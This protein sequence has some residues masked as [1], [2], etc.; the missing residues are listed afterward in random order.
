MFY[1][2]GTTELRLG[3]RMLFKRFLRRPIP[4]IVCYIPGLCKPHPEMSIEG[5]QYWA[6]RL[7]D[8]TVVSFPFL[9]GQK[10]GNTISFLKRGDVG[11][12]LLCADAPLT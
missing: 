12:A 9:S 6:F 7:G 10:V 11:D 4:G 5:L 1:R 3:D 2:D 8:G